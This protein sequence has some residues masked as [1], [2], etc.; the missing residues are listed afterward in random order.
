M[1]AAAAAGSRLGGWPLMARNPAPRSCL[2]QRQPSPQPGLREGH[3]KPISLDEP[4][5]K[6]DEVA[7]LLAVHRAHLYKLERKGQL[8]PIRIGGAIRYAPADVRGF[9]E[10]QRG[11]APQS[12]R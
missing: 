11:A 9:L 10:R 12:A 7:K 8:V 3:R 6:A 4:L 5:M 1:F 2:Q